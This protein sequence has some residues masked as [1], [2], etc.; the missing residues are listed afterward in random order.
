MKKIFVILIVVI[1]LMSCA[2]VDVSDTS[3][4]IDY[5]IVYVEG[6][7]CVVTAPFTKE[8]YRGITCDWSQWEGE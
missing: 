2:S 8:M 1:L 5:S 4:E 7:P 3:T 6:M